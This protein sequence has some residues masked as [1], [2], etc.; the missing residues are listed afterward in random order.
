MSK[1][2]SFEGC[3]RKHHG[4]GLCRSHYNQKW[5]GEELQPLRKQISTAEA[6]RLRAQ[7]LKRCPDCDQI[8]PFEEFNR[9]KHNKDGRQNQCKACRAE[10]REAN[11]ERILEY[12][13]QW[14]EANRERR[15]RYCEANRE[16]R[17]EYNRQW[18]KENPDKHRAKEALRR[19]RKRQAATEPFT[20]EDVKRIWGENPICV[21]CQERPAEHWDHFV[22]LS[23]GGRHSVHNLFPA[24]AECN[25]RKR[26]KHPWEWI[27]EL[28]NEEEQ[29]AFVKALEARVA[30]EETSNRR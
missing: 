30:N 27:L 1:A 3:E 14:Y 28:M 9:N 7:G 15:R 24:C 21:Y 26:D 16:Q 12:N 5:R 22:P 6:E 20:V 2:C 18:A 13:R 19:A 4:K 11:R 10:Y 8:K 29:I 25:L 17:R 23:K